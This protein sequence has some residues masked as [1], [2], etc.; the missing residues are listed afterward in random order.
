V[1]QVDHADYYAVVSLTGE[2]IVDNL[3]IQ[4]INSRR[5]LK[6]FIY[7]PAQLHK[8]HKNWVPPIYE[9]EWNYFNRKKNPAFGYCNTVTA[10]AR[11][12][13]EPVGRIMGIINNRYNGE[14]N[15]RSARFSYFECINDVNVSRRL[16]GFAEEWAAKKGMDRILG[17]FGMHYLDPMGFMIEGFNEKPSFSANYNFN[18]I[19]DLLQDAGYERE[20]DLV[21]YKIVIADALSESYYRIQQKL[22]SGSKMKV[23]NFSR[24]KQMHK[25]IHPVLSLMNE[26]YS[27]IY[28]YS[29]FDEHEMNVL[30]GHYMS[31]L[32][33]RFVTVVTIDEEVA[34]FMIA[35]PALNDGIIAA[36]GKL[37]PFGILKILNAAKH[38]RQ[39]D[40]LVGAVKEKYRGMGIDALIAIH[41]VENAKKAGFTIMD[42]HLELETNLKIRAEM[43]KLGGRI[44]K[45]YRIFRKSLVKSQ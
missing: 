22:L 39:L 41:T 3:T 23:V 8:A 11:L 16:L 2:N 20:N 34:G 6:D 5:D 38:S 24:R 9:E 12:N 36:G 35:M 30:A 14:R 28:G 44:T 7:L 25:Y 1:E 45:R 18:Y 15:E 33:P 17:P 42:S 37:Y 26:S 27:N 13:G 21:V 43:E 29:Q 19:M 40:L 4:E 32:D 31:F 10:L